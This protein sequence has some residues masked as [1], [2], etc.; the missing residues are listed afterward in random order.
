MLCEM[1]AKLDHPHLIFQ[2]SNLGPVFNSPA[3]IK[4]NLISTTRITNERF[5]FKSQLLRFRDFCVPFQIFG[6][7][8]FDR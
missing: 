5:I 6:A 1:L 4:S 7:F 8:V 2:Q 3:C